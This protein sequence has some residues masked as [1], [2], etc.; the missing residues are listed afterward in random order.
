MDLQWFP[1]KPNQLI[2]WAQDISLYGIEDFGASPELRAPR[3]S[4]L[5]IDLAFE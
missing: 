4:Q 5:I 2:T 3:N 1:G